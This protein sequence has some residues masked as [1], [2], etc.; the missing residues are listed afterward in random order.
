MYI[1]MMVALA[2]ALHARHL[3]KQLTGT[4]LV[5]RDASGGVLCHEVR[6]RVCMERPP[7]HVFAYAEPREVRIRVF[8]CAG[9]AYRCKELSVALPS[10]ACSRLGDISVRE[11][12]ERFPSWLQ[13]VSH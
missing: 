6:R 13:L 11:F 10:E 2:L 12:D 4:M 8:R 5:R 9:V 1:V 7:A 3:H